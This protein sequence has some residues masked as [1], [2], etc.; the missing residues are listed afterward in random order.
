MSMDICKS[1]RVSVDSDDDPG[2][3]APNFEWRGCLCEPCRER[4][5]LTP[6]D[7][8]EIEETE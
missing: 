1:C 7:D 8:D 3:Y 6:T 5:G 2:C 4:K